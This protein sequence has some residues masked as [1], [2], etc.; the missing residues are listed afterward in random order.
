MNSP[1]ARLSFG[2]I[3]ALAVIV[4]ACGVGALNWIG[5]NAQA[6]RAG[7]GTLLLVVLV[8]AVTA[9]GVLARALWQARRPAAQ[10]EPQVLPPVTAAE[11]PSLT[12][13]AGAPALPA[14]PRQTIVFTGMDAD[15]IERLI[16]DG[17]LAITEPPEGND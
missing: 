14:P 3:A 4:V 13:P 9:A 10:A 8:L 7:V 5:K 11:V 6:I 15:R 16:R 1:F 17:H 12:A 2:A